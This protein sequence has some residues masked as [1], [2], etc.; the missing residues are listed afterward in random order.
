ME[1]CWD[2][3]GRTQITN[4]KYFHVTPPLFSTSP[5][6]HLSPPPLSPRPPS[7]SPLRAH[8]PFCMPSPKM[9]SKYILYHTVPR[10]HIDTSLLL[11]LSWNRISHLWGST[12]L[13]HFFQRCDFMFQLYIF[14][15]HGD[16]RTRTLRDG[17][18]GWIVFGFFFGTT[19]S[20]VLFILL[21]VLCL[22]SYFITKHSRNIRL[23]P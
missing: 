19:A 23:Q 3:T 17:G 8:H 20:A 7:N 2:T 1:S 14:F 5:I 11:L 15:Q 16:R 22:R 12:V 10:W 18:R 9:K 6:Y 21:L 4:S 13:Q